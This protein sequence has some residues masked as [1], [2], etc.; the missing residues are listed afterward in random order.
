MRIIFL[1]IDGV[2]NHEAFYRERTKK[3]V[4]DIKAYELQNIDPVCIGHLNQLCQDA[5]A[6]VVISS[7]W[8]SKGDATYF[9]QLF[10]KLGFTGE[11][12]GKTPHSQHRFRGLEILD[13]M[14][15]NEDLLGQHYSDYEDYVILDDDSDMLYWQRNNFLLVDRHVGITPMTVFRAKRILRIPRKINEG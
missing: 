15:A 7:S 9:Q 1:D 14:K 3:R 10:S 12:V 13:W 11:V 6:K 2:L 8:R 5:G 4:Q